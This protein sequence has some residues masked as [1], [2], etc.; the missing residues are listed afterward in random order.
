[1]SSAETA[2]GPQNENINCKPR[3]GSNKEK[4]RTARSHPAFSRINWNLTRLCHFL[5]RHRI[6]ER[7]RRAQLLADNLDRVLRLSLAEGQKFL[8][9]GVL[10]GEELLGERPVLNFGKNLLHRLAAFSV[11]HARA[12]HVVAP[13]GGVR[14]RIA[15]VSEA[16]AINQVDDQLELVQTFEVG[17][18]G[19][20]AG[21]DESL[22]SSLNQRAHAATKHRLLA[23]EIRFCLLLER[24]LQSPGARAAD[25]FEVAE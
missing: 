15:H 21:V 8:L 1:M 20:I 24:R 4:R 5:H 13:L 17:A 6:E 18:L 14:N 23:K 16:A 7:H 2:R 12:A 19:L 10:V 11:D 22:I 3:A 25:A 9:T